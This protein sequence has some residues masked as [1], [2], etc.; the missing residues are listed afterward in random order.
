M[1]KPTQNCLSNKVNHL[2]LND[3]NNAAAK[4]NKKTEHCLQ[5]QQFPSKNIERKPSSGYHIK[6]A[7][8]PPAPLH[9]HPILLHISAFFPVSDALALS[10]HKTPVNC[11]CDAKMGVIRHSPRMKD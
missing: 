8:T 10:L 9:L 4:K 11:L 2:N 6:Q 7:S 1:A 5:L 3:S